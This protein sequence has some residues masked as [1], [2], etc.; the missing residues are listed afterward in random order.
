MG[1]GQAGSCPGGCSQRQAGAAVPA[2][3]VVPQSPRGH[4]S[5]V[6]DTEGRVT[7]CEQSTQTREHIPNRTQSQPVNRKVTQSCQTL[8]DPMDCTVEFSRPEDWN[9]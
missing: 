4:R 2:A 1:V 8:C 9:G 5:D 7:T 6:A 3:A